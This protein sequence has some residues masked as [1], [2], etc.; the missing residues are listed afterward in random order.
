MGN[1]VFLGPH[2]VFTNDLYPRAFKQEWKIVETKVED[3]VSIG[4]N[5]VIICGVT[6]G[7]FCMIGSGSV[8][9]KDIPP[10]ALVFGNPAKI[11]GYVCKCGMKKFSIDEKPEDNDYSKFICENCEKTLEGWVK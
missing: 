3:G 5:S 4:A 10:H 2:M 1:N 8:V 6:L 11:R 7:K 9:T